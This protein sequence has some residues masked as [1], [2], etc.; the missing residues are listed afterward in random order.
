[1]KK[2]SAVGDAFFHPGISPEGVRGTSEFFASSSE[3]AHGSLVP[4]PLRR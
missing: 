2:S 4:H 3:I 1:M